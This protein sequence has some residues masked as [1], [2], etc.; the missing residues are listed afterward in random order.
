MQLTHN[1][2]DINHYISYGTIFALIRYKGIT[3][4]KKPAGLKKTPRHI[5]KSCSIFK[6]NTMFMGLTDVTEWAYLCR[7]FNDVSGMMMYSE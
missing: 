1:K 6:K 5:T 7:K 4:H 3:H 2:Q